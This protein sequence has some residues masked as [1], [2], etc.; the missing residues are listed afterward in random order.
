MLNKSVDQ[1]CSVLGDSVTARSKFSASASQHSASASFST[2]CTPG[3]VLHK[4]VLMASLSVIEITSFTLRSSLIANCCLGYSIEVNFWIVHWLLYW[5]WSVGIDKFYVGAQA[6][7]Y[8]VLITYA[9]SL[10]SASWYLALALASAS[11]FSFGL[12]LIVSGLGLD[13]TLPWPH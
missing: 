12:D 9:T 8:G 2:S 7:I 4:V 1:G 10:A 5:M 11:Q 13:L 6:F 3:L